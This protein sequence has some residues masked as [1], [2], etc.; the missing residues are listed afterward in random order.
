VADEGDRK[1]MQAIID[2]LRAW[3][4]VVREMPGWQTRGPTWARVPISIFEHH[5]ASS[6]KS[7]EWGAL[8]LIMDGTARG[9]PGMLSQFQHGRALDDVPKVAIIGCGRAS[10]AGIGGPYNFGGGLV[11][12]AN[13]ANSHAYGQEVANNGLGEPY[14]DALHYSIDA[15]TRAA[16]EVCG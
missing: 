2:R 12:P 7:G 4:V 15:T 14:R 10:H 3:G 1:R 8:G 16:L 11:M 5:D 13:V 9:I 6:I